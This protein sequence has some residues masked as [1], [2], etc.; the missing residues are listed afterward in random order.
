[1]SGGCP[2]PSLHALEYYTAMKNH[3]LPL[4]TASTNLTN[5]VLYRRNL[6]RNGTSVLFQV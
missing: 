4:Y 2:G 6:T 5:T 3:K 1:M